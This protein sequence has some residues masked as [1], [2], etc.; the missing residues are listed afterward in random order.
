MEFDSNTPDDKST[1]ISDSQRL[2]ASGKQL[3]ITPLHDIT[4][5]EPVIQPREDVPPTVQYSDPNVYIPVE[6]EDTSLSQ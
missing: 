1:D 2:A 6:S 3:T 4:R 5:E